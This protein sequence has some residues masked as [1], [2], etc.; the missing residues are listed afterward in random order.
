MW[1]PSGEMEA[2]PIPLNQGGE[3][4]HSRA[5]P[6]RSCMD[7]VP[8]N[9]AFGGNTDDVRPRDDHPLLQLEIHFFA[10]PSA[11]R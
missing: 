3:L 6:K 8:P 4:Q 10:L 7:G 1:N 2:Q 9:A 5:H 11:N